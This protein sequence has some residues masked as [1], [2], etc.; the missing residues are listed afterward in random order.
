MIVSK[1][2]RPECLC[3]REIGRPDWNSVPKF[4]TT[5]IGYRDGAL[6]LRRHFRMLLGIDQ[7]GSG[8]SGIENVGKQPT[9]ISASQESRTT[10]TS[11]AQSHGSLREF[12]I[13]PAVVL[14]LSVAISVSAG[15][16]DRKKATA[17]EPA[18]PQAKAEVKSA[19]TAS[20][21]TQKKKAKVKWTS[22]FDGKTL[23]G[24]SVTK[25]GG[26]GE[27]EV[28]DGCILLEMGFDT[29]GLTWKK[30]KALPRTNYEVT[31]EAMRVD[32]SDFFCALTF[33]VKKDPC[34][35][36]VGGWGGGV[37]GLSSIDWMDASE[38]ETTTYRSFK[39]GQW[40][41]IRLRVTDKKIQAWIDDEQIVDQDIVDR[42]ISIRMELDLSQPFGIA[43]WQTKAA[44]RHIRIRELSP[45]DLRD[46]SA[47]KK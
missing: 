4:G 34:S 28:K 16:G 39:N 31:L 44:L 20:A 27:V 24:W 19:G 35:L 9:A 33:P 45:Q 26:E 7:C 2:S 42:K 5:G 46:T 41:R 14:A 8:R 13:P 21:P 23:K 47:K 1:L 6:F 32:G 43:C 15:A 11:L 3:S 22:M 29:T 36:I 40:Y 25:F 10:M 37:C 38:N 18:S 12:R 30:E 17:G